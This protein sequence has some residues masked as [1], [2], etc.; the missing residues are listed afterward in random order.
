M[1]VSIIVPIYNTESSIKRC[2][3]SLLLQ[4]FSEIEI[5]LIDDGSTDNS[6]QICKKY[7]ERDNRIKYLPKENGGSASAR[8]YGL[9]YVTGDYIQ[10]V[11]SDDYIDV[12]MTSKLYTAIC[13][14]NSDWAICG[15]IMQSPYQERKI[16]FGDYPCQDINSFSTIVEKYYNVGLLHSCCNKLYKR[17][18]IDFEMNPM[19][20]WGEDFIFNL[21]YLQKIETVAI[22][23][24]CLYFYDCTRE[25]VTRGIYIKQEQYIRERYKISSKILSNVFHSHTLDSIITE[26]YFKDLFCDLQNS[27]TLRA[28]LYSDINILFKGNNDA[29]NKLLPSNDFA[30]A[31]KNRNIRKLKSIIIKRKIIAILRLRTKFIY[32]YLRR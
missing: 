14:N 20:R 29:V 1:M 8:N 11:D 18:L 24:D 21:Q 28:L 4:T 31:I 7:S 9:K 6:P 12:E 22:I 19:Y 5:L 23:P 3:E 25:S 17:E 2:V 13:T 16:S 27:T 15:M 10:F 32:S 26:R 30:R